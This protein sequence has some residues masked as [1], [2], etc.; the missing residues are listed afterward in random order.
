MLTPEAY[1]R[2]EEKDNKQEIHNKL[3]KYKE[4]MKSTLKEQKCSYREF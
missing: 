3:Y 1:I 2:E 4:I